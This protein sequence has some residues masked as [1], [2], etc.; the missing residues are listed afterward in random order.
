MYRECEKPVGNNIEN[1]KKK[2]KTT[3]N[4]S[5]GSKRLGL[6]N[7]PVGDFLIRIKNTSIAGKKTVITKKTSLIVDVA[8]TLKK[9]GFLESI[10]MDKENITVKIQYQNKQP[11]LTDIKLV[12]KPGLRIYKSADE[13][14]K[15]KK[16]TFLIITTSK[17][18]LS[19]D[20]A[21]KNRVGGEVIA[22]IL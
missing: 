4:K 16:P 6:I 18:V 7:Y 1:M 3:S 8:K 21:L 19:K 22:E 12:S 17:G 2:N 9:L 5:R 15:I 13:L 14:E 20:E 11:L 10:E